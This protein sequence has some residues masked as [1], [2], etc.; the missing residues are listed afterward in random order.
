MVILILIR[1]TLLLSD[2]I[3]GQIT[4]MKVISQWPT[5][6]TNAIAS[7]SVLPNQYFL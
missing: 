4:N 6:R 2:I 1:L 3:Q 5:E 7:N